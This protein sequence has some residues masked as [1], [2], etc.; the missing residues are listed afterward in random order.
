MNDDQIFHAGAK[1][2]ERLFDRLSTPVHKSHRFD[3]DDFLGV[4]QSFS[5]DCFEAFFR[6]QN[7]MCGRKPIRH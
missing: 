7:M 3:E 1:K 2:K 6:D 5:E 4:D